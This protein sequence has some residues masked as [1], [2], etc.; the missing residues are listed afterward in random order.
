MTYVTMREDKFG[1]LKSKISSLS[2]DTQFVSGNIRRPLHGM[3]LLEDTYATITVRTAGGRA[4]GVLADTSTPD[5]SVYG[6]PSTSN[7]IVQRVDETR[8][9][10]QQ[11][12]ETFGE[13]FVYYYGQR[14]RM[15]QVNAILPDSLDF[16]YAQE[17]WTNYDRALRGTKLVTRDARVFLDVAGQIFEG[18][19]HTAQTTR[20]AD[21]PR[22]I[23]LNFTMY[24]THSYYVR[25]LE[26]GKVSNSSTS[27]NPVRVE[28]PNFFKYSQGMLGDYIRI[29]YDESNK[30]LFNSASEISATDRISSLEIPGNSWQE[31]L[32]M[33]PSKEAEVKVYDYAD[34]VVGPPAE[35]LSFAKPAVGAEI[36]GVKAVPQSTLSKALSGL[37]TALSVAAGGLIVAGAV[38]AVVDGVNEEGSVKDYF[39]SRILDPIVDEIDT[40]VEDSGGILTGLIDA[41]YSIVE[42]DKPLSDSEFFTT[43]SS[44]AEQSASPD[45]PTPITVNDPEVLVFITAPTSS[46]SPTTRDRDVVTYTSD[47]TFIDRLIF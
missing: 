6:K 39:N 3:E 34:P 33:L 19:L 11:I 9:E 27:D 32:S 36:F 7:L 38:G 16:Q 47:D 17:F 23:Q 43:A 25:P 31:L 14:P 5:N 20:S 4:L 44:T 10:K 12:I 42:P 21:Q 40:F 46:S 13:D 41:G 30:D 18:Y 1:R 35:A 8:Q 2:A 15:L 28:E 37:S 24:I 29:Q 26:N 45:A 22:L